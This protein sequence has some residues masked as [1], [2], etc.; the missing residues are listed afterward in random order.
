M[1]IGL[2][3]AG[4]TLACGMAVQRVLRVPLRLAPLSGLA[5]VA[6]LTSWAALLKLPP[7]ASTVL[8]AGVAVVGL[9]L[10]ARAMPCF[11]AAARACRWP[12]LLLVGGT[13]VPAL[14]LGTALG[15]LDAPVSTHDGAFHVET[16]DSLRHGT[17]VQT[18]YPVGFHAS[19]AALLGMAP[20][21]D[22]ARGTLEA[23]QGLAILA[24]L[25]V[26]AVGLTLGADILIACVAAVILALTWTYPYDYHLWGGWPQG[27]GVLLLLGL[28]SAA[29]EWLRRPSLAWA[30]LG[31]LF[32]GA[33]VLSHG[34]EV[35]SAVL[36]LLVIVAARRRSIDLRRLVRH[37]PL[38]V[39]LAIVLVGPYLLTVIGWARAGAATSVGAVIADYAVVNPE[40][41]GRSDWL[42]F[43]LGVTGAAS[44]LDLPVRLVL[45][46]LGL[47]LR[48][49]RLAV[50]L[51]LAFALLLIAVD[52]FDLA[53]IRT[54]FVLTYPWLVDHRP[55]QIAVI[56]ASLLTAGGLTVG[57]AA[58]GRL[59]P[60]LAAHPNAWRR[61][62]IA[63][64]LVGIFFVEGSGVSVYKRIVQAVDEQNAFT[65]DDRAAMAWL[66]QHAQPGE[67]LANDSFRDAGTWAPYKAGVPILL[68]RSGTPDEPQRQAILEHLLDL[69]ATPAARETACALHV[70]FVYRG[71]RPM[72]FDPPLVPDR[73]TLERTPHLQEVFVSGE[74]A[75]FRLTTPCP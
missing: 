64:A 23:A 66:R 14:M 28:W 35:Y 15:G 6:V 56:F 5:A 75:I 44:A 51:W 48:Q 7:L 41:M 10:S 55:R 59:R 19:V 37:L 30:V 13:L 58:L 32:A 24:P 11:L 43:A 60:R 53:P 33:I 67:M 62:A 2:L 74:A 9:V 68:P 50:G 69:P 20:W 39:A 12:T 21:L 40:D 36:G 29:L 27:M 42:Q 46:G 49:L 72:P 26:V 65:D 52:F 34:T 31:G 4:L 54:L 73:A 47:R 25:A 18:W 8:L 71:A 61:V 70:A 63:C 57:L 3:F 45:I 38:A 17:F 1:L 22:S 16:I